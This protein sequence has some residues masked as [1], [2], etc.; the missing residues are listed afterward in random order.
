VTAATTLALEIV[1][2]DGVAL[3]ESTVDAVVVHRRERR[4][5]AGSEIALLPGHEAMVIRIPVAPVR[6][7]C[8]GETV[9]LAVGGGFAEVLRNR[10]LIVTPRLERIAA[11]NPNPA[12]TATAVCREW[13]ASLVDD[14]HDLV[15]YA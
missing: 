12:A 8:R 14:R 4:F 10:V 6:Y 15:G 1:T 5:E 2:P 9:H 13:R 7:R 3:R 11:G